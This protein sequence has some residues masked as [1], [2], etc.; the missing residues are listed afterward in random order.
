MKGKCRVQNWIFIRFKKNAYEF[1]QIFICVIF[2][3]GIY[4]DIHSCQNPYECHTLIQARLRPEWKLGKMWTNNRKKR[5]LEMEKK[6]E[7]CLEIGETTG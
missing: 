6:R 4:S 1:I 5:C 7:E 2:L 3:T